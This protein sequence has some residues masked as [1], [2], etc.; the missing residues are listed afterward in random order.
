M[1]DH[2]IRCYP[3]EDQAVPIE[4]P[5]GGAL[6]FNY[7]VPHCTKA[8]TTTADRAGVAFHFLT[9][10]AA[11]EARAAG[12]RL[13]LGAILAGPQATG[14]QAEYGVRVDQEWTSTFAAC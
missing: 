2:H 7:G 13:A 8:N 3:P 5:A 10:P 14:G 12:A 11:A 1:S 6:F 4:L 9:A